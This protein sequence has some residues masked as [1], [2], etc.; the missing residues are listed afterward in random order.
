MS[1][2]ITVIPKI[3]KE[4]FDIL[5]PRCGCPCNE[6]FEWKERYKKYGVPKCK[7]GHARVIN[8][9]V[10][11]EEEFKRTSPHYCNCLDKEIIEWQYWFKYRGIPKYKKGHIIK[12]M[13]I[14][15]KDE[16]AEKISK[17]KRG[18]NHHFFGKHL[19]KEHKDKISQSEKGRV[20]WN[21]GIPCTIERKKKL[22]EYCG[23]KA[24]NWRGGSSTVPYCH[25]FNSRFKRLV[26]DRDNHTCQL[27]NKIEVNKKHAV[28]HIHYDKENCEPDVIVLC[29]SCNS[30]VNF[31]REYYEN[32]FMNMLNNRKLLFWTRRISTK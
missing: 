27:C 22:A 16:F 10:I 2:P 7:V 25:K 26:R 24:N 1:R 13:N 23:P 18:N 31:N 15:R 19:S 28:H 21:K 20:P 6:F 32:L 14:T 11:T 12:I 3:T 29:N 9:I 4:E 5:Q 17:A 8:N 30:K